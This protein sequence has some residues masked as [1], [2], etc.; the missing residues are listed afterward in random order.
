MVQVLYPLSDLK[1]REM[2]DDVKKNCILSYDCQARFNAEALLTHVKDTCQ[3]RVQHLKSVCDFILH[4]SSNSH[5]PC[6]SFLAIEGI[7]SASDDEVIQADLGQPSS[8]QFPIPI[9]RQDPRMLAQNINTKSVTLSI[10]NLNPIILY[11]VS[12]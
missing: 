12:W 7:T 3:C 1:M 4:F 11:F 8:L 10:L 2:E 5:A 6:Q 9:M